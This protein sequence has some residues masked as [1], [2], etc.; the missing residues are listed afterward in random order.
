MNNNKC[1]ICSKPPIDKFFCGECLSQSNRENNFEQRLLIL[2][3]KERSFIY[4]KNTK[5]R[6]RITRNIGM[7]VIN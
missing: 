4:N 6:F 1:M 5:S 3:R 7:E 2:A